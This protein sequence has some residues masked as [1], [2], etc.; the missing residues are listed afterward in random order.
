MLNVHTVCTYTRHTHAITL[1][2]YTCTLAHLYTDI[3]HIT[4]HKE[5]LQ[6]D[7]WWRM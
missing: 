4:Q 1:K 7:C 6:Y 3:V 2:A 5:D